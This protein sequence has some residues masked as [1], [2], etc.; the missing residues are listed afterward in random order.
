MVPMKRTNRHSHGAG[1]R[2]DDAI[3][4]IMETVIRGVLNSVAL[5]IRSL[6]K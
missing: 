6:E 3:A 1:F 5:A 2:F 4:T